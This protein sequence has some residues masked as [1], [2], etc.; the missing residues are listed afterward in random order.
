V[1]QVNGVVMK[2]QPPPEARRCT[3][4]RWRLYVF[5]GDTQA[6]LGMGLGDGPV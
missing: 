1:S 6:S 4:P 3:S 2:F 5:K